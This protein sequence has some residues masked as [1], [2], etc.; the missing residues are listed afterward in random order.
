MR[1]LPS[2]KS[3]IIVSFGFQSP[4]GTHQCPRS[5]RLCSFL[6]CYASHLYPMVYSTTGRHHWQLRTRGR[7]RQ[8]SR[9]IPRRS[10]SNIMVSHPIFVMNAETSRYY[11][12][13]LYTQDNA[14]CYQA[15]NFIKNSIMGSNRQ[16]GIVIANGILPRLLQVSVRSNGVFRNI[17]W[18]VEI[19]FQNLTQ[20]I[21][22]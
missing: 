4:L 17:L 14:K 15:L 22:V 5:R 7:R 19:F 20:S 13:N 9:E 16:K 8:T 1:S 10:Q 11:I 6:C 21:I 3:I 12:D 2:A 18:V